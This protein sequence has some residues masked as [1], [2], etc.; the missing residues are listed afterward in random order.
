[1]P[2]MLGQSEW[3]GQASGDLGSR[4]RAS[5]ARLAFHSCS[6]SNG[7]P[8]DSFKWGP[9]MVNRA[10]SWEINHSLAE[11]G[12]AG[13]RGVWS[14]SRNTYRQIFADVQAKEGYLGRGDLEKWIDMGR[15]WGGAAMLWQAGRREKKESWGLPGG[16]LEAWWDR[17]GANYWDSEN[18]RLSL[19]TV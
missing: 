8:A 7:R 6:T 2:S 1:M 14:G 16:W 12:R 4:G 9:G 18:R 3:G 11:G 13:K 17:R 15:G 5:Q 19:N 10:H